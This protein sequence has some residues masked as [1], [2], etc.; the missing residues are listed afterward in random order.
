MLLFSTTTL[1]LG[2]CPVLFFSNL[3]KFCFNSRKMPFEGKGFLNLHANNSYAFKVSTVPCNDVFVETND[4]AT[5]PDHDEEREEDCEEHGVAMTHITT[6]CSV[7]RPCL[8]V[9]PRIGLCP[10]LVF[11]LETL[12]IP[13]EH[14]HIDNTLLTTNFH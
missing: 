3:Q 11:T 13:I 7:F 1:T 2:H 14:K 12:G 8:T 6:Q 10:L 9:A 4:E 5:D